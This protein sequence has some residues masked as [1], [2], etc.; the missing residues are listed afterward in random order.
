[1]SNSCPERGIARGSQRF[2]NRNA[3]KKKV[4]LENSLGGECGGSFW[5]KGRGRKYLSGCLF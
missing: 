5:G 1:M 3:G 4:Q 2:V